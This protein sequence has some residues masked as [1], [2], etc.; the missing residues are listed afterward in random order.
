M[1]TL[2]ILGDIHG[3]LPALEAVWNDLSQFDVERVIVAGDSVNWGPFSLDVLEFLAERDCAVIRGNNELYLLDYDSGR[4]PASWAR[5]TL[6][7]WLHRQI[8]D[9]WRTRIATWPDTLQLR[10]PDAAP[11]RVVHGSPRDH[12]EGI[13][14][15]SSDA[16][17]AGMLAGVEEETV[18]AAHTHLR[19]D[20]VSGRHRVLN[21]GSVGI[22]LDGSPNADYLLL[23]AID[24][25]WQ[26]EFR[27][28]PYDSSPLFAEFMRQDFI[29][30]HGIVGHFVVE[31]FR[32][33][34]IH[35]ASFLGWHQA[36][37]PDEPHTMKLL[38]AF[39]EEMRRQYL[40]PAYS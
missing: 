24:G 22:P 4:A 6:P 20:R 5:Y 17:I 28:V 19:L 29:A 10:F 13:F 23:H 25:N 18:V 11:I 31:E 37:C 35:L 3:N 30:E 36:C 15:T 1:T 2:A 21:P 7:A 9:V 16:E 39:T 8:G 26:A 12:W 40:H 38:E 14:S 32:T 34:R 33:S 27:K